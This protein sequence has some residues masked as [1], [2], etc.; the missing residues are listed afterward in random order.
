[1]KPHQALEAIE[2]SSWEADI[3]A[4]EAAD[5]LQAPPS[6][7]VLFAG[8]SSFTMWT[9]VPRDFPEYPVINRGF[10]GSVIADS[11]QFAARIIVPCQ[12]RAELFIEDALHMNRRGYELWIPPIRAHLKAV[13][14]Q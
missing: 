4:F 1:M 10:G 2:P 5:A 6:Q 12:P 14:A 13:Y 9:S 8:S 3:K 11:T 7:G